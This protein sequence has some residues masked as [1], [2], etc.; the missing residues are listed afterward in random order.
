MRVQWPYG[1]GRPLTYSCVAL[2]IGSGVQWFEAYA[3][4]NA[5][6]R[7][8]VGGVS[9]RGSVG[10]A[11]GWLAGGGHSALSPSYGLGASFCHPC[12][13]VYSFG[14]SR[15]RQRLATA[16]IQNATAVVPGARPLVQA[17]A[18]Q[19]D[20]IL[21]IPMQYIP[22]QLPVRTTRK[23]KRVSRSVVDDDDEE[24][25]EAEYAPDPSTR[26]KRSRKR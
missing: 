10:A 1:R 3:A 17:S 2:T 26:S 21:P 5:T 12:F 8:L 6:G 23:R 13:L 15:H 4:A 22:P 7:I 25:D 16:R 9:A 20:L 14:V 18:P 19:A 11:G 24:G